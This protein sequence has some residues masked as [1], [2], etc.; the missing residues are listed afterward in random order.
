MDKNAMGLYAY[1]ADWSAL[2]PLRPRALVVIG[3]WH[4]PPYKSS[5]VYYLWR[6]WVYRWRDGRRETFRDISPDKW[7]ERALVEW[8]A[9]KDRHFDGMQ[10]YNEPNLPDESGLSDPLAAVREAVQWGQEVVARIR[11]TWPGVEVHTP[12]LSPNYGSYRA[13]WEAMCPLVE[14]CD[15]LNV[16]TYFD[17]PRSYRTPHNLYPALPVVISECGSPGQGTRE[18]ADRIVEYWRSL[19]DY[20]R[21]AAPF[22][23]NSPPGQF[24]D[25]RLEGTPA[26]ARLAELAE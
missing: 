11:R 14:K 15:V 7:I 5:G 9:Y 24:D 19:P 6:P 8:H 22:V 17:N 13:L 21:W 26:A 1:A 4:L 12:P 20:V 10:F 2:L 18:G 16:H 23:W 3:P 25:W